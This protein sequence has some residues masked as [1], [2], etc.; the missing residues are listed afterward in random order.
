ML[1]KIELE[2]IYLDLAQHLREKPIEKHP[3]DIL[4]YYLDIELLE[5]VAHCVTLE[6]N[7]SQNL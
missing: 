5:L 2:F 7:E 1:H 6:Q 4:A 3:E